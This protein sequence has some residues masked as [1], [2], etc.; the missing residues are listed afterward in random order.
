MK[1]QIGAIIGTVILMCFAT[2]SAKALNIHKIV[3]NKGIVAWFVADKSVPLV[4]MSFGFRGV[5]SAT[6]PDGREGL[7]QMV[8]LLLDEGAG[9]Q[10][11][12][13][14]QNAVEDIAARMS[15][16]V[17]RDHFMGRLRTLRSTRKKAFG[18][19]RLALT[20]PRFDLAPVNRIRSQILASLRRQ[21]EKPEQIL[22][23]VWAE[24]VFKGHPYAKPKTGTKE[25]VSAITRADLRSYV[26][27]SFTRERLVV[28]VVG[29]ISEFE[30]KKRLDQVFG[31]LPARG[32]S[33]VVPET[34]ATVTGRTIVV[35]KPIPQSVMVFGHKGL[36]RDDPD[37]YAAALVTRIFGGGNLNSRLYEEIREKRGLAYSVYAY[38]NP[39]QH[40]ALLVGGVA[41]QNARAIESLG[42]IRAEWKKMGEYGVTQ[43]ELDDAKSYLNGVFPLRFG[44]SLAIA[45]LLVG[46]QISK[47]GRNYISIR[48]SLIS[49]VTL[50]M[51]NRVAR[52]LY[53]ARDITVVIVGDPQKF[54]KSP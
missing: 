31:D 6:D 38:L 45:D 35:R 29:D 23:K 28:G 41:T 52:Q 3:S 7:A 51:A 19:L 54:Q 43:T 22:M 11:S 18:L 26:S 2:T 40:S 27:H 4:A 36:K 24:T 53:K 17:G 34:V 30:L 33:L 5:G 49:S 39:M 1:P 14:Y 8:S 10:T 25:T 21:A 46:M 9:A 37:W 44:S 13:E 20:R 47:L 50:Q 48:P 42:L 15:F 32:T 12:Q 16:D